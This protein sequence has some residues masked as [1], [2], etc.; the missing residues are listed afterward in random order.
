MLNWISSAWNAAIL[1][2]TSDQ[3]SD[4][5]EVLILAVALLP[6]IY[7]YAKFLFGDVERAQELARS[8]KVASWFLF[9]CAFEVLLHVAKVPIVWKL[10]VLLGAILIFP[11]LFIVQQVVT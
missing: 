1:F 10:I 11:V 8:P 9:F 5:L 4:I 2:G 3:L 6:A 7:I